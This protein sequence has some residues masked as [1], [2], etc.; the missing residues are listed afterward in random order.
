M[1]Q[2]R[3]GILMTPDIP[4][5]EAARRWRLVEQLGFDYLYTADHSRDFRRDGP[6]F[7]GWTTL[8]A[9]ALATSRIRIGTL[10]SNPI[11]RGP[12]LL[13]RQAL[14]VDHLSGGRLELGI[15][16]GIARFDHAAMGV[17]F[18]PIDERMARFRE[19]M[20]IVDGLLRSVQGYVFPGRFHPIEH[21]ALDPETVQRP[22]PPLILGGHSPTVRALAA[23][24]GDGW[25]VHGT[26][27][28]SL[29]DTVE[30]VGQ[31]NAA[32]DEACAAAGRAPRAVRRSVVLWGSIDPFT[33]GASLESL[34]DLFHAAGVSEFVVTWPETD[35]PEALLERAADTLR[36]RRAG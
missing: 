34:V 22:R 10:V 16:A 6:W 14:A 24:M 18:W 31:Q 3:S 15:G 36:S 4:F 33:P 12:T 28:R 19:Y 30:L 13:A 32:M 25:N 9:M 21:P 23:E 35:H 26:N 29:E 20:S 1:E 2:I 27:A 17:P 8:A 11:L 7:D 5:R